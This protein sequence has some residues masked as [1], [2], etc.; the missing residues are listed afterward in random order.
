MKIQEALHRLIIW[1]HA[2]VRIYFLFA[3][4]FMVPNAVFFVTEP[5]E[6]PVRVA[7]FLMPLGVWLILLAAARKPGIVAWC[8]LPKIVLDGGQLIALSVFGESVIAVDMLLNLTSSNASE[9]SELLT[10]IL[11]VLA[12][13]FFCY[14]VPTLWLAYRSVR[15]R[16]QLEGSFRR[17]W[18]GIG[19]VLFVIG[20]GLGKVPANMYDRLSWR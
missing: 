7:A 13:V 9:A 19:M 2:Q 20:W 12:G 14:T 1:T 4:L 11:M 16:D 8:L 17:L 18:A 10:N 5:L 6:L 15:G 3:L